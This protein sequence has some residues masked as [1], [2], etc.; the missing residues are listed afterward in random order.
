[1]RQQLVGRRRQRILPAKELQEGTIWVHVDD[2]RRLGQVHGE[3]LRPLP[4]RGERHVAEI[5]DGTDVRRLVIQGKPPAAAGAVPK[6]PVHKS[7]SRSLVRAA[8][9]KRVLNNYLP[10]DL[11]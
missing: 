4:G 2:I 9:L 11:L 5:Q 8:D 3:L 10:P 7:F 1:M 6:I